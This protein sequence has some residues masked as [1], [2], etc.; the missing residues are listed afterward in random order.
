MSG[1]YAANAVFV[2]SEGRGGWKAHRPSVSAEAKRSL[3]RQSA[4]DK[5]ITVETKKACTGCTSVASTVMPSASKLMA[6]DVCPWHARL[7]LLQRK[8][9]SCLRAGFRGEDYEVRRG[10]ENGL[11]CRG[12]AHL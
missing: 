2:S 7:E 8:S 4:T 5:G 11:G 6:V 10:A 1:I 9:E 3:M 12:K